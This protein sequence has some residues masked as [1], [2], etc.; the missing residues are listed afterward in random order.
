ME[1]WKKNGFHLVRDHRTE[2][3]EEYIF[4]NEEVMK[5]TICDLRTMNVMRTEILDG[6]EAAFDTYDIILS[7]VTICPPVRNASDFN[8]KGPDE[9]NGVKTEPLIGFCETFF[10]NFAG[11]PAASIPA[12]LT[13]DGLPVGIQAIGRRYRDEDVL[14]VSRTLEQVNPWSY[15]IP[16]G[17]TMR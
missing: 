8:T 13:N 6:M 4:W 17:R 15:E 3:P 11:N 14:A 9:V 10:A 16:F 7:P 12:G 1:L 5:S 2:L